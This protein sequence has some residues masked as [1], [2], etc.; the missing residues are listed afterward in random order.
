MILFQYLINILFHIH[1]HYI[2]L[3][4]VIIFILNFREFVF[5]FIS[6]KNFFNSLL[7]LIFEPMI[8][9][10]LCSINPIPIIFHFVIKVF[11]LLFHFHI[12]IL[13]SQHNIFYI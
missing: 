8:F 5:E 6:N 1:K 3:N 11:N 4:F 9:Q 2:I 10:Y 12:L 13:K 7:I